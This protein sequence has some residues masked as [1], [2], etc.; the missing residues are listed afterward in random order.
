MAFNDYMDI[1]HRVTGAVPEK[2]SAADHS[3]QVDVGLEMARRQAE[4]PAVE[5]AK[6]PP[7]GAT[8][9]AN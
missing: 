4:K 8:P 7:M 1:A 3:N 5:A 6:I 9:L 2:T